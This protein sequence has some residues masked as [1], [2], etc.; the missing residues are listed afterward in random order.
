MEFGCVCGYSF[1]N[2]RRFRAVVRRRLAAILIADVVGYSRLVE[3]EEAWTLA[4]LKS[5]RK[6]IFEPI[7]REY[8]G[9]IVRFMGD[10]ALVEFTSAVNAVLAGNEIQNKME[11]VNKSLP[12]DRHVILRI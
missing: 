5:R 11:A 12:T 7:V 2:C 8:G 1:Y 4:T 3:A 6:E 9:R 10:G